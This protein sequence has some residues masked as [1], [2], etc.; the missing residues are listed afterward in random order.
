MFS[1]MLKHFGESKNVERAI[2]DVY[3]N[4]I[5]EL[6][7]QWRFQLKQIYWPEIGRRR[8]PRKSARP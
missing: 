2:K 5:E 3:G 8:T 4:T 6:G 1:K 7:E